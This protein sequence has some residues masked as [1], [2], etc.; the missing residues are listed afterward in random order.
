MSDLTA[1][2][3]AVVLGGVL[4]F[5]VIGGKVSGVAQ[6]MFDSVHVTADFDAKFIK[7]E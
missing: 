3:A 5:N 1:L 6:H 4:V 7:P 2:L